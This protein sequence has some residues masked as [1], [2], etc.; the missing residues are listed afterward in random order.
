MEKRKFLREIIERAI[1]ENPDEKKFN[2]IKRAV[3]KKYKAALPRSYQLYKEATEQERIQLRQLLLKKP[4]RS[5]SGV[6]VVAVMCKPHKCPHGTCLY[7][8]KGKNAPQSYTGD[9]PAARRARRN[10]F[11]A[12]AQVKN[13]IDQLTISGHPTD[14][15]ELILMGGTF[16]SLQWSYQKKFVRDCLNAISG[17]AGRRSGGA[18]KRNTLAEAQKAAETSKQRPIG[19]TIETSPDYCKEIHVKRMLELGATRVELGV[20]TVYDAIFKK[21]HR[22][23]TVK[24]VA[25]ATRIAKNAG[26]KV[27]YHMM[28][29][30]PGSNFQKDIE[31][32]K[33]IFADQRFMPDMIKIY[34]TL[35]MPGTKLYKL[36]KQ[37]KYK[38]LDSEEA[39]KLVSKIKSFVPPWV[40]IMRVQ[41]DIPANLIAAGVK[42]SNL[43]QLA[44]AD[45]R[46]IRC[47][48][49]G[50]KLR[51]ADIRGAGALN[52]T[53][54]TKKYK[55]S[56][57][58]EYFISAED[59][60]KGILIGY[61]RLRENQSAPRKSDVGAPHWIVR[62]LHVYGIEVPIGQDAQESAMQHRG[63][64][65]KLLQEA[66]ALAKGRLYILSG[67]GAREYY[68]KL[69]YTYEK[70]YMVKNLKR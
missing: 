24:D 37:G 61:L 1:S 13:R 8:P 70:P 5:L 20:Q 62:E 18:A 7:C 56:D 38:P 58:M 52:I 27:C 66:E 53:I 35:V 10:K 68:K 28:P 26:L 39:A 30:L 31:A 48:E 60:K 45:C 21:V 25:D 17:A 33:K 15:I 4:S 59:F 29:G 50:H 51:G 32:F 23:H 34:P 63:W 12:A 2:Q 36:W 54:R 43:R 3:A 16:P 69:G 49:I 40:R 42:K 22:G 14:K 64:G 57:G 55:A 65:K 6:S 47:R 67:I 46:C 11:D 9:E 41:R 19:L 44:T